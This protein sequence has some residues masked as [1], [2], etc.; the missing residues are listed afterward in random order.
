MLTAIAGLP[1]IWLSIAAI[2]GIAAGSNGLAAS[3]DGKKLYVA[4]S[5]GIAVVETDTSAV[6]QFGSSGVRF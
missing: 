3:P 5:T 1:I 4:H 2:G 6:R